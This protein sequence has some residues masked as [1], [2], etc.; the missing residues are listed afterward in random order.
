MRPRVI[1][2]CCFTLLISLVVYQLYQ[3]G[4]LEI[5]KEIKSTSTGAVPSFELEQLDGL[6]Y[7]NIDLPIDQRPIVFMYLDP[8][9]KDCIEMVKKIL[10]HYAEFKNVHLLMV[11]ESD[12]LQVVSFIEE[13]KIDDHYDIKILLDKKEVMYRQFKLFSV[14][15]F[16]VYDSNMEL[17]KV[18]DDSFNFSIVVKYVREALKKTS[19]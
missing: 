1:L 4:S 12:K 13:Y 3:L 11:T 7:L 16:V 5:Q 6:P 19:S 10:F 17:V 15:S 2:V 14:P 9:C 18:I 8:T